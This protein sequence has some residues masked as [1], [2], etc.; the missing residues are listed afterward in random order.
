MTQTHLI[1][2]ATGFVGAALV[3]ELLE[4]TPHDIV[5]LVR[6]NQIGASERFRQALCKAAEVYDSLDLLAELGRCRVVAGDLFADGCGVDGLIDGGVTQVWHAAA[7]LR[8]ENRY[9]DEIRATNVE[10]TRRVLALAER[11]GAESFNYVSTA[12][13]A[14]RATGSIPESR[15]RVDAIE[16][17]NHYE[18]SKIDAEALVGASP[19]RTRIFRPS[20]VVGHSRTL[21]ATAFSGFYGFI[22]QV[23][24]FRGMVN[25]TQQGLLER[26]PVRIQIDLHADANLI[27]VDAVVHE[28]VAIAELDTSAGIFHLTHPSPPKVSTSMQTI[29]EL[30]E[31]HEPIFVSERE[32]FTWLDEQFDKRMDFYGSYIIGDKRFE[33]ART[34]AAQTGS[35]PFAYS[36]VPVEALCRWYLDTLEASRR[37]LPVAR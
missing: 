11:L 15:V 34:D 5:A 1:T 9:R 8:F 36:S 4:R 13:V 18:R 29:F 14:G 35:E 21:A 10:G 20:I 30:L 7:S 16:T 24:Q 31:L 17:N 19:M 28:A 32:G 12:Y 37:N 22:R 27:P 6:P 3:L 25:R 23:A 26:S 2:G 33:R